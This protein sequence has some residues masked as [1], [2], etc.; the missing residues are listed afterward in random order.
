[1]L[2]KKTLQRKNLI[3]YRRSAT[4]KKTI[5]LYLINL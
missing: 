5:F 4:I 1:M 3:S 2:E